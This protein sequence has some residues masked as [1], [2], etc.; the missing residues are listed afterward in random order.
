MR[1]EATLQRQ[2]K[3][4]IENCGYRAVACSNGAVLAGNAKQRAIQMNTLKSMG[5]LPGFPDLIVY[6]PEG[7]VAHLEV[8]IEGEKADPKQVACHEWMQDWGHKVAVVRSLED[9]AETLEGWGW[10]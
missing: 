7:R 5:L 4:F 8:K 10:Q 2:I 6:G 9:V 1:P 3:R